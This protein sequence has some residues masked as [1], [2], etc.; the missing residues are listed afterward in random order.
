VLNSVGGQLGLQHLAEIFLGWGLLGLFAL[1]L[2]FVRLVG[3][4]G[5]VVEIGGIGNRE[6]VD[7]RID[8]FDLF[9][10]RLRRTA[11]TPPSAPVWGAL[12]LYSSVDVVIGWGDGRG[13]FLARHAFLY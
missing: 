12:A 2:F 5:R 13:G 1:L 6:V 9:S 7:K 11:R 8:D 3:T 10:R 4:V